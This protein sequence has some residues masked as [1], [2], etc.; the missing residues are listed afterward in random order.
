MQTELIKTAPTK[1]DKEATTIRLMVTAIIIA[2]YALLK[3][4]DD[5]RQQLKAR[6]KFA[7]SSCRKVQQYFLNH[8][9]ATEDAKE[10]FRQHF[11]GDEIVL[12]YE[13][14]ETCFGLKDEDIE[15]IISEIKRNM[16]IVTP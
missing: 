16:E 1:Q 12:L 13:L 4:L 2:E 6:V 14:L 7:I 10:T 15:S 3:I 9:Q 5:T 11:I 8:P